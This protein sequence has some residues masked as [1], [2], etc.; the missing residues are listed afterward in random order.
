MNQELIKKIAGVI[1]R[2]INTYGITDTVK[3]ELKEITKEFSELFERE[4]NKN[5]KVPCGGRLKDYK[6]FNPSQFKKL[7]GAE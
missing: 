2:R 4:D 1:K 3:F 7:C 6:K 5:T